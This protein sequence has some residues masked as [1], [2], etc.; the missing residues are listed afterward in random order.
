VWQVCI[1]YTSKYSQMFYTWFDSSE[2]LYFKF[3]RC[4]IPVGCDDLLV[5]LDLC[6]GLVEELTGHQRLHVPGLPDA[7]LHYTDIVV[8]AFVAAVGH[9]AK[10]AIADEV[11]DVDAEVSEY[12]RHDGVIG[13][14]VH[15]YLALVL[16]SEYIC[17]PVID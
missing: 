7:D 9:I 3:P 12:S 16:R 5:P 2:S 14:G 1:A 10:T 13:V 15:T 4:I 8:A 11:I 6:C 17:A